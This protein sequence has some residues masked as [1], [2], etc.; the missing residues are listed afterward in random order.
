MLGS[1]KL[2]NVPL[3]HCDNL[4]LGR[5][6]MGARRQQNSWHVHLSARRGQRSAGPLRHEATWA[7]V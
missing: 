4:P 1:A 6:A 5:D 3:M 2:R 7:T